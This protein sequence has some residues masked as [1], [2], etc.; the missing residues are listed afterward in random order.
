MMKTTI[1]AVIAS[2]MSFSAAADWGNVY[3]DYYD[4]FGRTTENRE[5]Q[6]VGVEGG[7]LTEKH[8]MYGFFEYDSVNETTF[9]KA[10]DHY[11]FLPK[12]ISIYVQGTDFRT[13]DGSETTTT[14]GLGYLGLSGSNW[15]FKPYVGYTIKVG[16]FGGDN[17]PQLGWS[18]F[19]SPTEKTSITNWTDVELDGVTVNGGFGAW[20][21]ITKKI[22]T[23]VQYTYSYK[24]AG[25]AGYGDSV[26]LRL[27][28]KF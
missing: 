21:D 10:T 27:G 3:V 12:D 6:V 4:N 24:T 15:N 1:A 16:D 25:E 9:A 23:G 7:K 22:Y 2:V 14:V 8:D 18:A 13:S 11:K 20:Y 28:M 5:T 17:V 19:W 26:G